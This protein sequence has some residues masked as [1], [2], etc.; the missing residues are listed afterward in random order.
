MQ[1]W[2][3]KTK[4]LTTVKPASEGNETDGQNDCQITTCMQLSGSRDRSQEKPCHNHEKTSADQHL[5][6]F[7][8]LQLLQL[9]L[10]DQDFGLVL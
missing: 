1:Q 6:F 2:N 9:S 8:Y 10:E 7:S 4:W 3:M 5:S